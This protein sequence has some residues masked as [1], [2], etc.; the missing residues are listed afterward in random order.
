MSSGKRRTV[1]EKL[2]WKGMRV[3][4]L[5]FDAGFALELHVGRDPSRHVDESVVRFFEREVLFRDK[6]GRRHELRPREHSTLVPIFELIG[7][8][9]QRAVQ[10]AD[11]DLRLEFDSGASIDAF[12]LE[13]GWEVEPLPKPDWDGW[14]R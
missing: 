10:T 8:H 2:P 4:R 7:A 9:V 1:E 13:E 12:E 5:W 14:K 6:A 11:W 3:G